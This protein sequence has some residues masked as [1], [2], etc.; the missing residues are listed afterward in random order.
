MIDFE[1]N[2]MKFKIGTYTK[3]SSQGIYQANLIDENISLELWNKAD[4]PTYLYQANDY[5]FSVIKENDK[6]GVAFFNQG[7]LIN[8]V[9]QLGAPPCYVSYDQVNQLVYSANY[10]G[11][12]INTYKLVDGLL[13]DHEKFSYPEGS[14]AHYIVYH[15]EISE[16]IVCNLGIDEVYFYQVINQNLELKATYKAAKGSGPRHAVVHPDTKLIYVFTELSSEIIVLKRVDSSVEVVQIISTLDDATVQ[17]WGAAIR[18]S[19]DGKYLYVS[20]RGHDSITVFKVEVENLIWVENVSSH[21]V[22]PRDF[23][24]SP[25]D[26]YLIV[27]NLDSNNL[28]LYKRN[29]E[30][31]KLSLINK[32]IEAFEPVCIVFEE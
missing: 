1:V 2:K 29:I 12:R 27:A 21:G 10:H 22:Q 14:K 8:Q 17:R 31:G 25:C 26:H 20:N 32:D 9:T 7:H 30:N 15:P 3:K 13:L 19:N 5:L 24:I 11:G 28:V 6:G 16:V 4:N 18:L 23:N